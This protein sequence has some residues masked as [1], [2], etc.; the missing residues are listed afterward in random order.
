MIE[1]RIN[2]VARLYVIFAD[3]QPVISFRK[4]AEARKLFME[5]TA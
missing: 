1:I 2:W 3:D 4:Y 5:L